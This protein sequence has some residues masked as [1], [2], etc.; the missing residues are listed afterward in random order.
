MVK[1]SRLRSVTGLPFRSRTRTSTGT[2]VTRLLKVC[3]G[4]C[5][6]APSAA[7]VRASRARVILRVCI[8]RSLQAWRHKDN[9]NRG[10]TDFGVLSASD[11][12]TA[13]PPDLP[14]AGCGAAIHRPR[15][16]GAGRGNAAPLPGD[17]PL[18]YQR[19]ARQREGGG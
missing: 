4:C 15:L 18:R 17:R 8:E 7:H 13:P 14:L 6:C 9:A 2:T 3:G 11:E 10:P 19:P 1:S 16:E 5:S 12:T